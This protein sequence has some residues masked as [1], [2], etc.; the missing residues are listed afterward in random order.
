MKSNSKPTPNSATSKKSEESTKPLTSNNPESKSSK[1][2]ITQEKSSQRTANPDVLE[3]Y[4][5][6]LKIKQESR[7]GKKQQSEVLTHDATP[8]QAFRHLMLEREKKF[9]AERESFEEKRR[10]LS[11]E[12]AEQLF[13]ENLLPQIEIMKDSI[14]LLKKPKNIKFVGE[15][16]ALRLQGVYLNRIALA[17]MTHSDY[18]ESLRWFR[19]SVEQGNDIAIKNI[20]TTVQEA[21]KNKVSIAGTLIENCEFI[22]SANHIAIENISEIRQEALFILLSIFIN[23]DRLKDAATAAITFENIMQFKHYSTLIMA[24]GQVNQE[25]SPWFTKL[26]ARAKAQHEKQALNLQDQTYAS[27]MAQ[28]YFNYLVDNNKLTD[29]ILLIE[30]Y[31][32]L[33]NPKTIIQSAAVLLTQRQTLMAGMA[34]KVCSWLTTLAANNDI[35]AIEQCLKLQ[36]HARTSAF[37]T[38]EEI[39]MV[40]NKA[41]SL[42]EPSA[43]IHLALGCMYDYGTEAIPQNDSLAFKYYQLA[44]EQGQP[45]A[46]QNYAAMYKN[47]QGVKK[48]LIKA[49]EWYQKSIKAGNA[50]AVS[51]LMICFNQAMVHRVLPISLVEDEAWSLADEAE[52][53]AQSISMYSAV[54]E[55]LRA[56]INLFRFSILNYK[57]DEASDNKEAIVSQIDNL[58]RSASLTNDALMRVQILL[59]WGIF[60]ALNA[61]TTKDLLFAES[62]IK[63]AISVESQED[64][65]EIEWAKHDHSMDY[66]K[67]HACQVLAFIYK[68]M[69]LNE[70]EPQKIQSFHLQALHYQQAA[71]ENDEESNFKKAYKNLFQKT[72]N[73]KM[74]QAKLADAENKQEQDNRN[75]LRFYLLEEEKEQQLHAF[76]RILQ[77]ASQKL[78]SLDPR[79]IPA[80]IEEVTQGIKLCSD[81]INSQ[82]ECIPT[83]IKIAEATS[84]Y[85]SR[86]G[87]EEDKLFSMI[88]N[89]SSWRMVDAIDQLSSLSIFIDPQKYSLL[90]MCKALYIVATAGFNSET[91]AQFAKK[92]LEQLHN[93]PKTYFDEIDYANI[94]Y[95]SLLFYSLAILDVTTG[96]NTIADL[97]KQTS[98]ILFQQADKLPLESISATYHAYHYFQKKYPEYDWDISDKLNSLFIANEMA[99][100]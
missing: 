30:R 36:C 50:E 37:F 5:L 33:L 90:Q 70:T 59:N 2:I 10:H 39:S 26:L 32:V 91:T 18:L 74:D 16:E 7:K 45:F 11:E 52:K 78:P 98:T 88:K 6:Q 13:K 94:S 27:K 22:L 44:A 31:K 86:Y 23:H 79:E 92:L 19:K 24:A 97:A 72:L 3:L 55:N 84:L 56:N 47:G 15:K 66:Y 41:K 34:K 58:C 77:Q 69:A 67:S 20:L 54:Y 85:A 4:Q 83:C 9:S 25:S 40:V 95:Y 57:Y 28:T 99:M 51:G 48:D 17:Y 71:D 100:I 81:K 21:L 8:L 42:S 38:A 53:A 35:L 62:I 46:M 61:K 65:W 29:A 93:H 64:D 76:R 75:R 43:G 80:L 1:L 60:H 68:N 96:L 49:W 63:K 14:E 12:K 89:V 82:P 73:E 87:N